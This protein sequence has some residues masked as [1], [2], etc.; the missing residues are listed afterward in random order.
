MAIV[1]W[2]KGIEYVSG[3][4][5]SRP[6]AGTAHSSHSSALMATHRKAETTNPECSR[7]YI[8]KEDTYDRTTPVLANELAARA[9]FTAV[10]NA[11]RLRSKDLMQINTDQAAFLAQRDLPNG[12]KT[13]KSYLWKVCGDAYDAQHS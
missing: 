3:L 2:M 12:K 1:K 6:K 4:L 10:G 7:L 5:S 13:M 8:R 9:R 11:V